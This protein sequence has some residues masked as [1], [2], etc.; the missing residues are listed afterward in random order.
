MVLKEASSL[1]GLD[2]CAR[3]RKAKTSSTLLDYI[4]PNIIMKKQ[5]EKQH[6]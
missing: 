3:N 1:V 4:L 2:E 6:H 5:K